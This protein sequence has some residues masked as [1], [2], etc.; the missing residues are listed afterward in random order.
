M[1]GGEPV[2][3]FFALMLR[4]KFIRCFCHGEGLFYLLRKVGLADQNPSVPIIANQL[5]LG[6]RC[7]ETILQRTEI[8]NLSVGLIV[9]NLTGLRAFWNCGEDATKRERNIS[10][11]QMN[12]QFCAVHQ[13]SCP[14]P[15][16]A[17]FL[18][19]VFPCTKDRGR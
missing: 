12:C 7:L 4:V 19:A 1:S 10:C 5:Q 6:Q 3:L 17:H 2:P 13:Q 9:P 14:L 18:R 8:F 11:G 15:A 16:H